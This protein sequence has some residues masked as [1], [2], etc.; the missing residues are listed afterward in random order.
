MFTMN[1]SVISQTT[2]EG[3]TRKILARGGSLMMVEVKFKKGGIG[4]IHTHVHEQISY[5]TQGSLEFNLDGDKKVLKAGDTVYIPSN[6]E[7]GLVS[8]EENSII[9]DVFNPQREDFLK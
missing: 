9:V 5:V 8:L 1:D 4:S 2:G 3:V 6:V 7:H